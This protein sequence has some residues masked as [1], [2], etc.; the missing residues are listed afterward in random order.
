LVTK[1]ERNPEAQGWWAEFSEHTM[2]VTSNYKGKSDIE[3]YRIIFKDGFQVFKE[4]KGKIGKIIDRSVVW[5]IQL[6]DRLGIVITNIAN[7]QYVTRLRESLAA[8]SDDLFWQDQD[9]N[10]Y[11][12][13]E[14][15]GILAQSVADVMKDQFK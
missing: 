14:A 10:R 15:A 8:L 12:D 9:G 6:I 1:L 13:A 11:F 3:R 2:H 5:L 4:Y 7:D